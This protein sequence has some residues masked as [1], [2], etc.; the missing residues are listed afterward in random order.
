MI[1]NI[2]LITVY[3]TDQ[4]E[5]KQFY[6]DVLGFEERADVTIGE[7]SVGSPSATRRSPSSR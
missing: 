1:T 6:T 5:A 4:D 7:A 3:V 2:S